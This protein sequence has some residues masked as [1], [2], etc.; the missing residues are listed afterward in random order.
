MSEPKLTIASDC[1][2]SPTEPAD[3][4][5]RHNGSWVYVTARC[6]SCGKLCQCHEAE[7]PITEE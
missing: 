1:C 3:G 5:I 6:T 4:M 7:L 2:N